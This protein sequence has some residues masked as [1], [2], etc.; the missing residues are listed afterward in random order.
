MSGSGTDNTDNEQGKEAPKVPAADLGSEVDEE[1]M[2]LA[3]PPPGLRQALF[4]ILFLVLSGFM[5]VWFSPELRYLLQAFGGP[6]Q[7]GEAQDVDEAS[8]EPQ[9]F[10]S[11]D[12][13]PMVNRTVTFN[14]GVKWFAMSDT[15]RKMFPLSG[16]TNL[17][18]QWTVPESHKAFGAKPPVPSH[19]E[20]HLVNRDGMGPNFDKVWLFYDCLEVHSLNRCKYCLGRN[21]MN[22][23]RDA[24]TCVERNSPEECGMI[25]GRSVGSLE[26][27]IAAGGEGAAAAEELLAARREHDLA[28]ASVR[29]EELASQSASLSRDH[30]GPGEDTAVNELRSKVLALRMKE[31]EIRSSAARHTVDSMSADA[32]A[33]V[34]AALQELDRLRTEE[35]ALLARLKALRS[36]V[37]IGDELEHLKGRCEWVRREITKLEPEQRVALESWTV[38]PE[39]AEGKSI[40]DQLGDLEQ[41]LSGFRKS[42]SLETDGGVE[43]EIDGGVHDSGVQEQVQEG[44]VQDRGPESFDDPMSWKVFESFGRLIARAEALQR[45]LR[46]VEIGQV[47]QFDRWA[48]RSNTVLHLCRGDAKDDCRLPKGLRSEEVVGSL[49]VL[50]EMLK[51]VDPDD[52]ESPLLSRRISDEM[53]KL[54]AM[55]ARTSEIGALAGVKEMEVSIPVQDLISRLK[56]ATTREDL[57]RMESELLDTKRMLMERGFWPPQFRGIPREMASLEEALGRPE[58]EALQRELDSLKELRGKRRWIVVDGEVPIDKLWVVLVYLLLGVMIVLNLRKLW[59]FW[60]AWRA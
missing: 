9:T 13:L 17:F 3:P 29:L 4:I 35:P 44:K 51:G 46:R 6:V 59:R 33:Q 25:L 28:V 30:E 56:T 19:F 52:P 7:L 23:C 15:E 21:N 49:H 18:V 42:A 20:G 27:E 43:A 58:I 55:R 32:R 53:E 34:E 10:V 50:E 22:E 24:F 12:G 16:K 37:E 2:A 47:P 41:A 45:K 8:L 38:D 57:D 26:S 14:E 60:I 48:A 40:N 36:F 31:L 11:I 1:L 39:T 54:E 5:I